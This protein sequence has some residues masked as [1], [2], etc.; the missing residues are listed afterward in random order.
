MPNNAFLFI[1]FSTP[2]R[3]IFS[4]VSRKTMPVFCPHPPSPF[5]VILANAT[6]MAFVLLPNSRFSFHCYTQLELTAYSETGPGIGRC[7]LSRV[8]ARKI[9]KGIHSCKPISPKR[10]SYHCCTYRFFD[11]G[12]ELCHVLTSSPKEQPGLKKL[13]LCCTKVR[14]D[15]SGRF[16]HR[17]LLIVTDAS[18]IT[19][20]NGNQRSSTK[21]RD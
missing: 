18:K 12:H 20:G 21:H 17:V 8:L 1:Y 14:C 3:A 10:P 7:D 2:V 5:P 6:V 15:T 11:T 16:L 13:H 9:T 4:V 19:N